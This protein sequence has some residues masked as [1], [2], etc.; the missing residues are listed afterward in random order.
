MKAQTASQINYIYP[1]SPSK[2]KKTINIS[3]IFLEFL[4]VMLLK[5]R[6]MKTITYPHFLKS[7]RAF[8]F[9]SMQFTMRDFK[10]EL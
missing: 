2:N 8:R 10:D 1:G 9:I 6:R 4:C 3:S 5:Y 7:I